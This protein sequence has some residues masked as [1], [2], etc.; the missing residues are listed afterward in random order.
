MAHVN[1]Q[2]HLSK[3]IDVAESGRRE[4]ARSMFRRLTRSRLYGHSAALWIASAE[5]ELEIGR[6]ICGTGGFF[7]ARRMLQHG[8]RR[9]GIV[10]PLIDSLGVLNIEHGMRKDAR[11]CMHVIM[12]QWPGEPSVLQFGIILERQRRVR[13]SL[14]TTS[15]DIPASETKKVS[16]NLQEHVIL[17]LSEPTDE[18][19]MPRTR[20][21]VHDDA[22]PSALDDPCC[23]GHLGEAPPPAGGTSA[24]TPPA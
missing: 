17:E 6:S 1:V 14:F 24:K 9:C 4:I 3:A 22:S 12:R 7:G 23:N 5:N 21:R 18:P 11:A 15:D 10:M 20:C 2:R 8:M 16:A 19:V 13:D